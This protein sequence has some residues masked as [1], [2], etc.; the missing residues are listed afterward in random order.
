MTSRFVI[1]FAVTTLMETAYY[2][3]FHNE[4]IIGRVILCELM[5]EG[6]EIKY[7]QV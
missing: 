1:G 3:R 7:R 6:C 4:E 5:T 2:G